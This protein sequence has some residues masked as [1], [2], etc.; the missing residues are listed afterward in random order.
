[1]RDVLVP[2][3]DCPNDELVAREAEARIGGTGC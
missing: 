3:L 2:L 1:M